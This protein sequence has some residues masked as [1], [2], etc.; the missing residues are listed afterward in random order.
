V[1]HA[2]P[3]GLHAARV[4]TGT[5]MQLWRCPVENYLL[6]VF[7]MQL[8][9]TEMRP[10]IAH[11]PFPICEMHEFSVHLPSSC[12]HIVWKFSTTSPTRMHDHQFLN[13]R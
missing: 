5:A 8:S 3:R 10:C 1:L 4:Q 12:T 6:A 2:M 7:F 9:K 13:S 11:L